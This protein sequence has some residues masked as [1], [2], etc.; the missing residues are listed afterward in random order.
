MNKFEKDLNDIL[1]NTVTEIEKITED[2][3]ISLEDAMGFFTN[4]CCEFS[5]Q[6]EVPGYSPLLSVMIKE[7]AR[8]R[9][10]M[11]LK[12]NLDDTNVKMK[13]NFILWLAEALEIPLDL[14]VNSILEKSVNELS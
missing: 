4:M 8:E 5:T 11:L 9:Y 1:L 3:G 2:D 12:H 14:V 6:M 10:E 13:V 7:C